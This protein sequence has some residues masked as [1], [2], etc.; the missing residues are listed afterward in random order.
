MKRTIVLLAVAWVS[1]ACATFATAASVTSAPRQQSAVPSLAVLQPWTGD[2]DGIVKRRALRVLVVYSR[3]F[4][5]VDKGVQRG[6]TYDARDVA[7]SPR[8]ILRSPR[9]AM[10]WSTFPSRCSPASRSWL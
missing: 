5:F 4:Y 2:W 3:T 1:I 8:R 10:R 9:R 7:T 6:L